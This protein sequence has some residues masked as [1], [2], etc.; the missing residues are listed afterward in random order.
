[1]VGSGRIWPLLADGSPAVPVLQSARDA[2]TIYRCLIREDGKRGLRT[3][4]YEEPLKGERSRIKD[5]SS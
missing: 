5:G 3:I 2:V 4:K 1:M